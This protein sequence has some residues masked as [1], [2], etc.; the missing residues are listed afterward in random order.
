MIESTDG[1][2]CGILTRSDLIHLSSSSSV[3]ENENK[4]DRGQDKA[5]NIEESHP[6]SRMSF[7][8]R[9][10]QEERTS[11]RANESNNHQ[12]HGNAGQ[13]QRRSTMELVEQQAHYV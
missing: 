3:D 1:R 8:A 4:D 5:L 13:Q 12:K 7:F 11:T 2:V 6:P 10:S 9:K